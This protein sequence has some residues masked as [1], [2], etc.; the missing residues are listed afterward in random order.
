MNYKT[1]F[2]GLFLFLVGQIG[3]WYQTNSQFISTWAKNNPWILTLVGVPVSYL[4]IKATEYIAFTFDGQIW[5]TRLLG[6]SMGILSFTCLTYIHLNEGIT[7]KTGVIL[8]L[9]TL[10][11][12]I[13][14]FWK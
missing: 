14:V 2:L 7:L 11:L 4:Y 3:A 12:I 9:A 13:Q 5:P 1:L 6:F 10:I 8:I